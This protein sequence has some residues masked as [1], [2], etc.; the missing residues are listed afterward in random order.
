LEDKRICDGLTG[1]NGRFRV[2]LVAS[3][4]AC[5]SQFSLGTIW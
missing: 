4:L 3:W 2:R 5:Y 1:S